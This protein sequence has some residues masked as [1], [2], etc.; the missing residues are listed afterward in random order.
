MI[1]LLNTGAYLV[2]GIDI[3]PDTEEGRAELKARTGAVPCPADA[4]K[5]TIAYGILKDHNVSGNMENLQIKFD[6]LTSHDITFVGIIQ[7][8]RASGLEKFPVPYVLTNCH[9]SLCAV[10][11]TINEDDHMFGLTCAKK[12][13][14]RLCTASSG[15]NSS[16]CPRDACRRRKNDPRI[17]LPHP[18]RCTRNHGHGR[19]RTGAGKTASLQNI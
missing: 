4:A 1:E 11:G 2:N 17:R 3:I 19:G 8:A 5:E 7:T 9:N 13:R 16:V 12:V 15:S 18:L 6:K 10:G 14:R